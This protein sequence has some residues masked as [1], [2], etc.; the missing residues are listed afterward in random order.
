M[1][2]FALLHTGTMWYCGDHG[3]IESADKELAEHNLEAVW[4]FNEPD[5]KDAA[6]FIR[7]KL[8]EELL[9]GSGS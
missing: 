6:E 7:V 5:A 4:I 3:D 1:K 2:Y 9:T 8:A